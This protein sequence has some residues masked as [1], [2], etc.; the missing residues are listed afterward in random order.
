[1]AIEWVFDPA[2][3]SGSRSGGS[4][5]EYGFKGQIDTLVR[6]TVQNSLDAGKLGENRVDIKYRF[7]ELTDEK[8]Q[9]FLDSIRWDSLRDNLESVTRNGELI[10][11][12]IHEMYK[13]NRLLLLC[14]EDRGTTGLTGSEQRDN[15]ID[16][17]RFSALVRDELYSD[18]DTEDAGGSYGL[19]KIL[20]W[21]YS[22]FKTVLFSSIPSICPSDKEGLRFIGRTSLPYHETKIDGRCS[23]SGW[24]GIKRTVENAGEFGRW[25]ESV[26]G[27][28]AVHHAF[29]CYLSRATDDYGLSTVIVGFEEPGEETRK[30]S[31]LVESIKQSAMESFWP[32]LTRGF[33]SVTVTHELDGDLI[34]EV[35][36]NPTEDEQFGILADLL[37]EYDSNVLEN[38]RR[39]DKTNDSAWI[40]VDIEVPERISGEPG[41]PNEPHKAFTGSVKVL[42][43]L[44]NED[45]NID[46]IKDHIYRFRRPGMVIRHNGGSGLSISARP[47][48]ASVLC[49]IA[50]GNDVK[51][52]RIEHFLRSAEPPAHDEWRHDTKAVKA[53]YNT[54]G[55]KAKLS[56]FD[57]NLRK[58]I[59][60]L[61]SLPEKKGGTL[62]KELLKHLRFGDSSGGGHPRFLTATTEAQIDGNHWTFKTKIMRTKL[63]SRE[64]EPWTAKIKL[65]YAVDGGS[66]N[67]VKAI[68]EVKCD[69]ATT[70]KIHKGDAL[71]EFSPDVSQANIVGITSED[72]LPAIGTHAVIQINVDGEKGGFSNAN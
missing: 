11:N 71:L 1:M 46:S 17:N 62:P 13:S 14:I 38:K 2:P 43:K 70:I 9:N 48:I 54:L 56:R 41:T 53:N 66:S 61:V 31:E 40:D 4:A 50:A 19:G 57:N 58:A 34:R 5:A 22:A 68:K 18:K 69:E 25:A 37:K 23:G 51:N 27:Q 28:E 8:M 12:A 55:I 60:D 36:V 26:W 47:Y 52:E 24:L 20:L 32:A 39:L 30:V 65:K 6:E 64:T 35:Q 72:D 10:Q 15:D 29:Q 16:T 67:D 59:R 7:I 21:A 33:I 63:D 3:P 44:L 42:V 49:G 45:N